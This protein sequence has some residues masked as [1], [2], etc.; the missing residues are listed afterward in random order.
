MEWNLPWIV[1]PT[2]NFW[3]SI[4]VPS[5]K[6]GSDDWSPASDH[7]LVLPRLHWGIGPTSWTN[8]SPRVSSHWEWVLLCG[9][10]TRRFLASQNSPDIWAS[11][12]LRLGAQAEGTHLQWSSHCPTC[13]HLLAR[14]CSLTHRAMQV[15]SFAHLKKTHRLPKALPHIYFLFALR[16]AIFTPLT[17]H[18]QS[19]EDLMLNFFCH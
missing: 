6:F 5:L 7:E 14:C 9:S 4:D 3:P 10:Q 13:H 17:T 12:L 8:F 2:I 11:Y 1:Y 16:E 15:S 18:L 19:L